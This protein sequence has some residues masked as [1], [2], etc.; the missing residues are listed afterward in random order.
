MAHIRYVVNTP[1]VHSSGPHEVAVN[2]LDS[3]Q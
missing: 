2:V 1:D 3:S